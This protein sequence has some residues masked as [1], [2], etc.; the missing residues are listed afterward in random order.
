MSVTPSSMHA[1]LANTV[2]YHIRL[3]EMNYPRADATRA[4]NEG[5]PETCDR[6]D[7]LLRDRLPAAPAAHR[8]LPDMSTHK[9]KTV[10]E[11]AAL[12]REHQADGKRVVFT[13]GCFDLLH[14]GHVELFEQS[15]RQGDLLVIGVNSDTSVRRIKGDNRPVFDQAERA[16]ILAAMASVD[17]VCVFDEDTPLET[18]LEIHPDVLVKGADWKDKGIVG[19]REVESWGG[20]VVTVDVV[21][22]QSTS[23]IL[24]RIVR[25][26]DT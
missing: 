22:G 18:I 13:N 2:Q 5:E 12:V 23:G 25:S 19:Q 15:R 9:I 17:L 26:S 7:I 20:K 1:A 24:E 3:P 8:T 10:D 4:S 6:D 21:E 11:A 16:E 14:P